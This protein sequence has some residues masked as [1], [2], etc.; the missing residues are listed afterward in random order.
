M[1]LPTE[2]AAPEW[3]TVWLANPAS[4][5]GRAGYA[6]W[7]ERLAGALNL[8]A[9]T[10]CEDP[11]ALDAAVERAVGDGIRRVIV[12]GGDGTV[13][14]AADRLRGT[15]TV[16]GVVP[17]GT[18]NTFAEGL[19]LPHHP[20]AL[21]AVL[22]SGPV[23]RL[24]LGWVEGSSGARVFL[25][26]VTLG[27]SARLVA[28]LTAEVKRRWG[29]FAW[30]LE[31]RRALAETPAVLARVASPD[32]VEVFRTRQLVVANGP[33]IA[34][35][36]HPS[37][38]SSGQDGL[39]EV[40]RLG[41][42]SSYSMLRAAWHLVRGWLPRDREARFR[43]VPRVEVATD[44]PVPVDVDGDLWGMTPIAC[45]VLPGALAVLAPAPGGGRHG[46]RG[47]RQGGGGGDADGP[48]GPGGP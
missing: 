26:S 2:R 3:P 39:L 11:T 4:R 43:R 32:G 25:N 1:T 27:V 18:G 29:W 47:R 31:V 9:A 8:V 6:V 20:E 41:G 16:L 48:G 36:I 21:A 40:F 30:P 17:L 14:R 19:G 38:D 24:D 37:A 34:G 13:S 33:T 42:P 15:P 22:A 7:R 12:G 23:R 10:L 28:L 46:R 44:P 45:R 5:S 35:P